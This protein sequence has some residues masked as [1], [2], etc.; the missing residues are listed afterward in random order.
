MRDVT[1]TTNVVM[2]FLLHFSFELLNSFTFFKTCLCY[3]KVFKVNVVFFVL[4][5][6]TFVIKNLASQKLLLIE[7]YGT[8]F[9]Y[10]NM[11]PD[12]LIANCEIV[13]S[14]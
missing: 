1:N 12:W 13:V 14:T 7:Q 8:I 11:V 9:Y 2:Q 6:F 4:A 10:Y 3:D 5:F